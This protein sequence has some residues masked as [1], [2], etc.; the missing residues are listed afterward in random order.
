[1]ARF[2]TVGAAQMGPVGRNESRA[3]VVLRL[4][5]ML[6]EAKG[7]GCDLV[8]FTECALTP[9]F[10]RFWEE[11]VNA[12]DRWFEREMPGPDT[13]LLFAEAKKLGIGFHLGFAELADENGR[14][15]HYNSSILVGPDGQII[16]RYRKIHLPG[17]TSQEG[18]NP[19]RCYEKRYFDI[20]NLGFRAWRAFGGVVGM[21][22]GNDRRWPEAYRVLA[23]QG[24]E[25]IL[26]GYNTA[27]DHPDHPELDHLTNYHSTLSMQAGAYHNGC[28]V[29]GVAKAGLEEGVNQ[30]GR[31]AIIAPSGEVVTQCTTLDDELVVH[32][33]NLDHA[34][35][36][37]KHIFN[38]AERREIE[39]YALITNTRGPIAPLEPG[40]DLDQPE[41][42]PPAPPKHRT[43]LKSADPLQAIRQVLADSYHYAPSQIEAITNQVARALELAQS[44]QDTMAP[45]KP[46]TVIS[47]GETLTQREPVPPEKSEPPTEGVPHALLPIPEEIGWRPGRFTMP[48]P[49]A[50]KDRVAQ[51]VDRLVNDYRYPEEMARKIAEF[52]ESAWQQMHPPEK[53]PSAELPPTSVHIPEEHPKPADRK[54]L[55]DHLGKPPFD[56]TVPALTSEEAFHVFSVLTEK[57]GYSSKTARGIAERASSAFQRWENAKAEAKTNVPIPPTEPPLTRAAPPIAGEAPSERILAVLHKAPEPEPAPAEDPI[58]IVPCP[59][60]DFPLK[61]NQSSLLGRKARCPQCQTKFRLPESV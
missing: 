60:C 46:R 25:I 49:E 24:A 31:S 29:V 22:L 48:S 36:Y 42:A 14:F 41:N 7:R 2:I 38:F 47:A 44:A 26:L 4:L 10:P 12:C 55:T 32:R 16:G 13:E 35:F 27:A 5:E 1:M 9:F 33:C 11:D 50:A 59:E 51:T 8:V 37:K 23:L 61:I 20:G 6:R 30:I 40:Q 39:A 43:P 19:H 28:F 45:E 57:Y 34:A 58:V 17:L 53:A 21:C 15:H 3:Q 56:K 54:P 52:A 18:D